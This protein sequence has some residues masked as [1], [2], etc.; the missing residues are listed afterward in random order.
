MYFLNVKTFFVH[1]YNVYH[2]YVVI[3]GKV[4]ILIEYG[5][6]V[7]YLFNIYMYVT[8]TKNHK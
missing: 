1:T 8:T 3:D 2:M 4:K 6:K 7:A 5:K